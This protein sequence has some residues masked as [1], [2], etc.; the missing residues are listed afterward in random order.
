MEDRELTHHD[1]FP[2]DIL[3]L[4]V[5]REIDAHLLYARLRDAVDE[6]ELHA[7]LAGL[8]DDEERHKRLLEERYGKAR[9]EHFTHAGHPEGVGKA[10]LFSVLEQAVAAEEKAR[11]FYTDY[12]LQSDDPQASRMFAEL[13]AEEEKHRELLSSELKSRR[14]QPWEEYELDNWVRDD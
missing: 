13:A 5:G 14:G 10:T 2:Q 6:P 11:A 1:E 3:S 9:L 7:L 12:A 4:A 8:A